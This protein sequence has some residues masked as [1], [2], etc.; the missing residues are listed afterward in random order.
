MEQPAKAIPL[1]E[2][3]VQLDPT[4]A[5]AHFRLSTL[6]RQAGRTADAKRQ[7]D[8]YLKYKK[9]REQLSAILK[10][11]RLPQ[12]KDAAGDSDAAR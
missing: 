11:L 9:M 4:N 3:A 12:A 2:S 5:A 6:Y 1:L 10:K 7:L 8:Q